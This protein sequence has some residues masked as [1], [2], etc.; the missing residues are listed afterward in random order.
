MYVRSSTAQV[1]FVLMPNDYIPPNAD[2][3]SNTVANPAFQNPL[4][5]EDDFVASPARQEVNEHPPNH[6]P[7]NEALVDR[8]RSTDPDPTQ[9]T[10]Y[11]APHP[12]DC[13][14]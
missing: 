4:A 13:E 11:A 8:R 5:N 14:A 9:S 7:V 12:E 1:A 3:T 10:A 2:G 6:V